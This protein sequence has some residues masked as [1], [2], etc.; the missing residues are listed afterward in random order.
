VG[1]IAERAG[2]GRESLYESSDRPRDCAMNLDDA[3]ETDVREEVATPLLSALGYERGMRNDILRELTL[4]YGR[5]FLGRKKNNNPP[6]RGRA[7]YVLSV[8]GAARWVLEI[9]APKEEI[10]QETIEQA[11][12]YARHPEVSVTY[13]AILN[14]KR[15][16]VMH[17]SQRSTDEP[18][19]N[20]DVS[21]PHELAERVRGLLSPASIKRDCSPPIVD[22]RRPLV[23][24][25]RANANITGGV[26][27]Y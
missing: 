3:N 21:S 19:V 17:N 4:S 10:T 8:T 2:L 26:L 11:I 25:F 5:V 13:A 16:V 9:K 6:L 7:D 1:A 27:I 18:L 12:S 20:I 14:G 23:D 15:F 24:G 22:L